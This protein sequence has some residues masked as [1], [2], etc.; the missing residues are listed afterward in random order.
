VVWQSRSR[1][2]YREIEHFRPRRA[3]Q[4]R[5]NR[6]GRGADRFGADRGRGE[7]I[8]LKG[9]DRLRRSRSGRGEVGWAVPIERQFRLDGQYRAEMACPETEQI[10][11]AGSRRVDGA[12]L[13][14]GRGGLSLDTPRPKIQIGSSPR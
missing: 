8:G 7:Q 12:E 13:G 6:S 3:D 9:A 2:R 14:R 10:R 5:R 1:P 11:G 4:P